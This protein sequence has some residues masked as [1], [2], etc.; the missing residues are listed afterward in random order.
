MFEVVLFMKQKQRNKA[1]KE[2]KSGETRQ[3]KEETK[4]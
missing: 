1:K 3:R 2:I 4:A